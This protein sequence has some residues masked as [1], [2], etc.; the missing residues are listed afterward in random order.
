MEARLYAGKGVAGGWEV[1]S[2]R[3]SH[4]DTLQ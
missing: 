1:S 3:F 2:P 4:H